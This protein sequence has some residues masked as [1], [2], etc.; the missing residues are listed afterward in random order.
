MIVEKNQ[1]KTNGP[2]ETWYVRSWLLFGFI[3]LY[4]K[5]TKIR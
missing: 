2:F 3:P 1:T 5:K 4:V